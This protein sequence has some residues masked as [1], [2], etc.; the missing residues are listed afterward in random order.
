MVEHILSEI[1]LSEAYLQ[2]ELDDDSKELLIINTH[3]GLFRFNRSP[4][5]CCFSTK[6]F[7]ENYGSNVVGSR[8][9]SLLLG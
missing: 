9:F 5:W 4:F 1:D 7:S 6:Y 2:V 3:K 8:R